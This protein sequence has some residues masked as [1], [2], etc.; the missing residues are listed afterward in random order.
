[1]VAIDLDEMVMSWI[2]SIG[3]EVG[4]DVRGAVQR[5]VEVTLERSG[6]A[7]VE[8]KKPLERLLDK[9]NGAL[10]RVNH[11]LEFVRK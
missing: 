2:D 11:M 4:A 9:A 6:V 10:D 7:W 3:G 1:M 5:F 8:T